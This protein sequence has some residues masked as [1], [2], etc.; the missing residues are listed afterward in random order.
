[1]VQVNGKL[2]SK[3]HVDADA[4]DDTLKE[5]AFSDERVLKF[6]DGKPIKKIIVVK[7]KLVNIVV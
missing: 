7:G 3:F 6:I 1:V 5:T 4:D 2:R